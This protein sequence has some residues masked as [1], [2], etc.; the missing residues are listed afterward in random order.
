MD[1]KTTPRVPVCN[2]LN[3][4]SDRPSPELL[5]TVVSIPLILHLKFAYNLIQSIKKEAGVITECNQ[6]RASAARRDSL[7]TKRKSIR[8]HTHTWWDEESSTS[9]LLTWADPSSPDNGFTRKRETSQEVINA[10]PRPIHK[11]TGHSTLNSFRGL[12]YGLRRRRRPNS[13]SP[14]LRLYLLSAVF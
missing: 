5:N 6:A 12:F 13:P 9:Q 3:Y 10:I 4:R 2:T 7:W 11:S 1:S 8:P 14:G